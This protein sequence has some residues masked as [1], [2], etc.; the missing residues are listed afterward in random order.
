[1]GPLRCLSALAALWGAAV[2]PGGQAG[3]FPPSTTLTFFVASDTHLD[4]CMGRGDLENN[5][6]AVKWMNALPG[7]PYPD[8]LGGGV[9]QEPVGVI[10]SGD[11]V[12]DGFKADI[13]TF[14]WPMYTALFGVHK[15]GL[16][17]YPTFE[18]FGNHDG[19]NS[20]N[21]QDSGVRQALAARNR[22]RLSKG[23]IQH[24]APNALHYSWD[25]RAGPHRIHF[26]NVNLY[27]GSAGGDTYIQQ[28]E[29]SLEFLVQDLKQCV[30]TSG[31]PVV[32]VSH[33]GPNCDGWW[34]PEEM[35]AFREA[36]R[37][38][39][40]VAFIHGHTHLAQFYQWEDLDIFNA[41]ATQPNPE[42]I[43]PGF[44]VFEVNGASGTLRAAAYTN[45]KWGSVALVKNITFRR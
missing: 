30:G 42:V 29:F 3:L 17:R 16:L 5:V 41:P 8:A 11:L 36:V 31:T 27:P 18:G 39:N 43:E 22:Q 38:Y 34:L 15:E 37:P 24:L 28:P 25:W 1:M 12:N 35:A 26:V 23:L 14:Q 40:V 44:L 33:Y 19:G 13:A 32:I 21:Q 20:T 6:H 2:L 10:V 9:V 4:V 7:T 45:A